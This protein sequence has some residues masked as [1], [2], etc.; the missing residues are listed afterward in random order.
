VAKATEQP[1]NDEAV[2]FPAKAVMIAQGRKVADANLTTTDGEITAQSSLRTHLA[3]GTRKISL[4]S[5]PEVMAALAI[6]KMAQ[7]KRGDVKM[8]EARAKPRSCFVCRSFGQGAA[9][10]HRSNLPAGV[11]CST[12]SVWYRSDHPGLGFQAR[13]CRERNRTAKHCKVMREV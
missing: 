8:A 7:K 9:G 13:C 11:G 1:K 2:C 10:Q 3:L 5:T 12:S 6:S 4:N